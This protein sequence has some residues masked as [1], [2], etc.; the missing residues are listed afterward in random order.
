M[1][2]YAAIASRFEDSYVDLTFVPILL[3]DFSSLSLEFDNEI[4]TYN[5]P[6][7]HPNIKLARLMGVGTDPHPEVITGKIQS[8]I[9]VTHKYLMHLCWDVMTLTSIPERQ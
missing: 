6:E 7:D 1:N 5:F 4:R 8:P 2:A 3:F 9:C